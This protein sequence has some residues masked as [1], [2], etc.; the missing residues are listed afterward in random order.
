MYFNKTSVDISEPTHLYI[1]T[2]N[3]FMSGFDTSIMSS[4][5]SNGIKGFIYPYNVNLKTTEMKY[6]ILVQA[7]C[8]KLIQLNSIFMIKLKKEQYIKS[9]KVTILPI[10]IH[11]KSFISLKNEN[12]DDT[13]KEINKLKNKKKYCV[14]MNN[15]PQPFSLCNK[16][17]I[18]NG[19][20]ESINMEVSRFHHYPCK[21]EDVSSTTSHISSQN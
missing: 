7:N 9:I 15:N 4:F 14:W 8:S 3:K 13:L 12:I 19:V 20:F 10:F 11:L 2:T 5:L 18:N 1:V 21:F 17:D 6:F 16:K